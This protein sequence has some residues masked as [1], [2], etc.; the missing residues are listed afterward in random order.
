MRSV[1]DSI[2]R[3]P[4][5][6]AHA[7]REPQPRTR[8]VTLLDAIAEFGFDACIGGA[9]RD[10]EKARAKER[11][12]SFRDE[13]GQ[14]DPKQPAP[15]ALEPL[16]RARR[17]RASTCACSRSATGPSSTSGST[18][19]ARSLAVPSIYFAH[20]RDG[21]RAATACWCRSRAHAAARRRDGRDA[22]ACAS[23][24]S[25]TSP[26]PARSRPTPPTLDAIIAETAGDARSPSAAPR[27][28]TTRP[29]T[30][31][32]S[33]ARRKATSDGRARPPR[34]A[35]PRRAALHHRRQRRRRQEHAD[36]PPALRHQAPS[37]RTSS[38]RSSARSR[39]ARRRRSTSRSSPTASPP[40]AS[41]ASRS[42]SPTA[43]SPRR[44]A[45]SSSPTRPATSST[46][47]TWSPAASHRATLA[48]LLV[49]A[50]TASSTQTR[51]HAALAHLL[52]IRH[53]VVAVN[54]MDLVGLSAED[55]FDGDRR[56]FRARSRSA[57]GIAGVALHPD[58]RAAT[59]TWWS[60]AAT[61]STGTTARR[62]SR[63]SRPPTCAARRRRGRCRFPVQFVVAPARQRE[64][65]GYLG[66]IEAGHDRAPATPSSCCR[67]AAR[68]ACSAIRDARRHARR[69]AGC[70]TSVT[71]RARPTSSTSRAATCIVACARRAGARAQ[72][73][74]PT[75][76]WLGTR[77]A[78]SRGARTALRHT[79]R[80][81]ARARRRASIDRWNV[82]DAAPRAG[83]GAL[84]MND[85]GAR[86][87]RARAADR[88]GP[89]RRQPRDGQLHPHRRSDAT[90]PSPPG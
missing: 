31:R 59:A 72:R 58:V 38:P 53:L 88:R 65:R 46:R 90:T 28:W 85:I 61:A 30:P 36:R 8:S 51:R 13:F 35:R 56:R 32:W 63:S 23:A 84:A 77:A 48:I 45:S 25:A 24:P 68:R 49:D 18:S 52:G 10:E 64:P 33:C 55:V 82:A 19:R 69:S 76:C 16:Q 22:V 86:R 81:G 3:G 26:A 66:R 17:T 21:R 89:L 27:A 75:S 29:P 43:T 1:E 20:E 71:L 9:R 80:D 54:K 7:G 62:C 83:A 78:R 12:F 41:R 11:I 79:T 73:S 42:T 4:R 57:L 14:W 15:G 70:T 50:R 60:I 37:S 67:P 87:A 44:S 47:A 5:R 6:A 74:R 39:A 34:R 2:A 40:S